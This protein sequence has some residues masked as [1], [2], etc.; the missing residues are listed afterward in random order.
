MMPRKD[1]MTVVRHLRRKHILTPVIFITARGE[2][3]DPKRRNSFSRSELSR[4]VLS[5]IVRE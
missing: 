3:E 4:V 1:G 5:S 2:V